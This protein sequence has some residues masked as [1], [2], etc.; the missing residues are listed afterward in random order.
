MNARHLRLFALLAAGATMSC[1][2]AGCL[3]PPTTPPQTTSQVDLAATSAAWRF[4]YPGSLVHGQRGQYYLNVAVTVTNRGSVPLAILAAEFSLFWQ[5]ETVGL[6]A[7]AATL[8]TSTIS[9]GQSASATVAFLST[10]MPRPS[11]IEFRQAGFLNTVSANVPAPLAPP[12]ELMVTGLSSNWSANGTGNE[13]AS[14]G[15][16]FLWVNGSFMNHESEALTVVASSF[17]IVDDQ[18]ADYAAE[19]FQGPAT[20]TQFASVHLSILFEVPLGFE[21]TTLRVDIVLGPWTDAPVPP[22]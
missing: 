12:I 2:M 15:N 8:S 5:N 19:L 20:L 13:T 3:A 1:A 4:D 10:Q 17:R 21:P 7:M 6:P 9:N 14:P 11:R 18:G 22:P 16:A